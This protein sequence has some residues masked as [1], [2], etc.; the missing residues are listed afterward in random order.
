[1]MTPKDIAESAQYQLDRKATALKKEGDLNGAIVALRK[2]K[3]LLGVEYQDDK[4]AKYLQAAGRFDDALQEIQWLLDNSHAW[5]QAMFSHQPT[6]VLLSQRTTRRGQIHSAAALIC[7]REKRP[8]LEAE[9]V[10]Q[11]DAC[12]SLREKIEPVAK[13]DSATRRSNWQVAR[14]QGSSAMRALINDRQKATAS[15]LIPRAQAIEP[16]TEQAHLVGRLM[17]FLKSKG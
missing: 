14:T 7:K 4:L 10:R 1:M 9:H 8:D 6:S 16:K 3:A 15:N 11:R 13:E 5:A 2:R 17:G 12:L